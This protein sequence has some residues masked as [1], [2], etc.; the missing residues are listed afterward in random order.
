ML[1]AKPASR[2]VESRHGKILA[3]SET[4]ASSKTGR[5]GEGPPWRPAATRRGT[6]LSS[7]LFRESPSPVVDWSIGLGHLATKFLINYVWNYITK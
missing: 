2:R 5:D 7:Q 4:A 6:A 1:R 3:K